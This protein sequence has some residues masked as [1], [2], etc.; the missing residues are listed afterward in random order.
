MSDA[1]IGGLA[2]AVIL[3]A[4]IMVVSIK[5]IQSK[6]KIDETEMLEKYKIDEEAMLAKVQNMANTA[7]QQNADRF[8]T[9]ATEPMRQLMTSLQ[10]DIQHL[11]EQSVENTRLCLH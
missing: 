4:V 1:A 3:M 8:K 2:L 10:G 7:M 11:K 5:R 6:F 9:E